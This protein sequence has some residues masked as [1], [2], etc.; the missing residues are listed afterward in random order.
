VGVEVTNAV[1]DGGE[2]SPML[3]QLKYIYEHVSD[4]ALVEGGFAT[5]ET[6]DQA[7]ERGCTV[8]APLKNE[9]KQLEQGK[10]P[11]APKKGDSAPVANWR[12]RM[13]TEEAKQVY[14]LRGQTTEWVN[15]PCR[16]R[17]LWHYA[18]SSIM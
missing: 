10:D 5:K 11:Y 7:D 9:Q 2:L 13:G 4:S 18:E 15:A 16:N 3:D 12:S 14:R 6:I 17:G 1:T 8:Y